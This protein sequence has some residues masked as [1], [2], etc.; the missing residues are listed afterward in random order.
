MARKLSLSDNK[1]ERSVREERACNRV[2]RPGVK[3]RRAVP[4]SRDCDYSQIQL[5]SGKSNNVLPNR[6]AYLI[7]QFSV[8]LARAWG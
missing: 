7:E 8:C 5:T 2:G 6:I 4:L 1:E 3:T